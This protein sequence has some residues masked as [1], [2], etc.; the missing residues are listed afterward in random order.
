MFPS[1]FSV[2]SVVKI[3]GA[4]TFKSVSWRAFPIVRVL[5]TIAISLQ[6]PW[7]L[8]ALPAVT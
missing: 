1:V 7:L 6:E 8:P 3:F 5:Y 2:P 4:K